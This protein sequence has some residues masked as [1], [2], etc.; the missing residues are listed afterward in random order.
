M[1]KKKST[2]DKMENYYNEKVS[3]IMRRPPDV[4]AGESHTVTLNGVNYQIMYDEEVMVPRKVKLIIDEKERNEKLAEKR[5]IQ[6]SQRVQNL[7][8]E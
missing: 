5:L 3:V 8:G 2:I 4:K 7:D 6:L 1:A